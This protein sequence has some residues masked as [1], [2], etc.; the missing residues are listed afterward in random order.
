MPPVDVVTSNPPGSGYVE[1]GGTSIITPTQFVWNVGDSVQLF[2]SQYVSGGTGIRYVF[3][4]WSDGGAIS[5]TIQ[6]PPTETTYQANYQQQDRLIISEP[7]A[8]DGTTNPPPAPYWYNNGQ[9]V[10]IISVPTPGYQ[11]DNW[12]VDGA[13]AGNNTQLTLSMAS[14]HNISAVFEPEPVLSLSVE[15]GGNVEVSSP[16]INSGT[17]VIVAGGTSRSFSVPTGTTVTLTA[18]ATNSYLFSN[19]TGLSTV[20]S[21]ALSLRITADIPITANFQLQV[22][23]TSTQTSTFRS[24]QTSSVN[25]PTS[26][27]GGA[28]GGSNQQSSSSPVNWSELVILFAAAVLGGAIVTAAIIVTRGRK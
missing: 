16:T 6:A 24:T 5:H 14:P 11:L 8:S 1:V 2:A 12:V 22:V 28:Q 26:S 15:T 23:S 13:S 19:W 18:I 3:Q 21:N 9:S 7:N 20:S 27:Q 25:L 17:P 4:N 10:N